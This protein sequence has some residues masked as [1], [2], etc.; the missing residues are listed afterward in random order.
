MQVQLQNIAGLRQFIYG[1]G[2][3][4]QSSFTPTITLPDPP[5]FVI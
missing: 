2:R 5:F 3:S 4:G 1:E